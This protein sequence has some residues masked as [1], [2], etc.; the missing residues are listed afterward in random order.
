MK[1]NIART[2]FLLVSLVALFAGLVIPSRIAAQDHR[3]KYT[4]IDLGTLG[5]TFSG[6]NGNV[7]TLL[8]QRRG[9]GRFWAAPNDAA[10]ISKKTTARTKHP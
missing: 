1:Y 5:G 9:F 7:R 10:R 6:T 3:Q 4:V 8:R 2:M